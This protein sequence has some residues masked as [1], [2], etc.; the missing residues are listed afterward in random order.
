MFGSLRAA[1]AFYKLLVPSRSIHFGDLG[2]AAEVAAKAEAYG[3]KNATDVQLQVI[4][5]ALRN[6]DVVVSTPTGSGKTGAYALPVLHRLLHL[7]TLLY[8]VVSDR[9]EGAG[10]RAWCLVKGS[11]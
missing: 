5:V 9:T 10:Y 11:V 3:W 4:P 1:R 8:F 2:L 6:Q 7:V